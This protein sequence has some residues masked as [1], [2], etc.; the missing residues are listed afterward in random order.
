NYF[1]V[2]YQGKKSKI[3]IKEQNFELKGEVKIRIQYNQ[4][5]NKSTIIVKEPKEEKVKEIKDGL[6][7]LNLSTNHGNL[8]VSY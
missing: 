8:E 1:N 2:T 5:K 6:V 7:I 3:N 4:K